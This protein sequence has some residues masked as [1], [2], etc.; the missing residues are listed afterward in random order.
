MG[1]IRHVV[2]QTM[3][4]QVSDTRQTDQLLCTNPKG[5]CGEHVPK[6][7]GDVQ[8]VKNVDVVSHWEELADH[9]VIA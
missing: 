2:Q 5:T 8:D 1:E 3:V 4:C 6:G 7:L 9:I